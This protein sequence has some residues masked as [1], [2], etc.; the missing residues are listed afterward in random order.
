[1]LVRSTREDAPIRQVAARAYRVTTDAPESDGTLEWDSTTIVVVEA[2]AGDETGIGWTYAHAA[3]AGV[4]ETLAAELEGKDA[5]DVPACFAA[6]A[7]ALR[8]V[9]R[10]G[11]GSTALSAVDIALWDLKAKLLGVPVVALLG[12]VRDSVELYGSGGFTS[13]SDERLAAQL[14][15]WADEG[16]GAVKIKVGREPAADP[17]R[18]G[19]ARDVIGPGTALFVD[20]NG[21]FDCGQALR[22]AAEANA[23]G[24]VWFEEPVSS[25][26]V[27]GLRQV[28]ERSPAGMRI[29]AGEYGWT[30]WELRRLVD[31]QAV[32]VLQADVTRC[33]GVTGFMAVAA[34][35]E[36]A[37]MPLSAH[38]SPSL[39]LHPCCAAPRVINLE[40]FHDHVRVEHLLFD[41]VCVP[42]GGRLA[43]DRSRPGLGI[44]LRRPD[45]GQYLV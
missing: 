33:G 28:R 44:E 45:A 32:D 35:C 24:V 40:Y 11:I 36:A 19:V 9:G 18:M 41:G 42:A 37:C 27:A 4:V 43:P 6:M 31:E 10:P 23:L 22:F 17:E 13:Y 21:A 16:F 25:D 34:L 1:V 15:E 29:A 7:R 39:H 38:T 12:G 26:D 5:M 30:P 14:G 2:V 20:A 3:A 8:N